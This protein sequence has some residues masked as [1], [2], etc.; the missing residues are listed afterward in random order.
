[1]FKCLR[2]GDTVVV[3]KLDRL[4]GSLKDLLEQTS[5]IDQARGDLESITEKRDSC[6]PNGAL[7]FHVIGVIAEFEWDRIRQHALE[8]LA[9]A[10]A[11]GRNGGRLFALNRDQGNEGEKL[12]NQ[13]R[14]L[15]ELSRLFGVSRA[16]IARACEVSTVV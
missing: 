13:G 9:A 2:P 8:R 11:R 10:R 7:I 1:M 15:T 16:T 14:S 6:S 4:P 3:V 12:H 5:R